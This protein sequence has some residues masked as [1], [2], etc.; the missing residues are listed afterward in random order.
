MHNKQMLKLR[1]LSM[2]ALLNMRCCLRAWETHLKVIV[3]CYLWLSPPRHTL[4][5]TLA[6]SHLA[7]SLLISLTLFP[8]ISGSLHTLHLW[9]W[10]HAWPVRLAWTTPCLL[11]YLLYCS[12]TLEIKWWKT[13]THICMY[14]HAHI[15][16]TTT[17]CLFFPPLSHTC[18]HKESHILTQ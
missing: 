1:V 14:T 6:L 4:Y 12:S 18:T 17:L 9:H 7:P 16:C 3:L 15:P 10:S 8:R 5:L 13:H 2:Q 11:K